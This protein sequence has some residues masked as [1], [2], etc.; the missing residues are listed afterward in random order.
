MIER[1]LSRKERWCFHERMVGRIGVLFEVSE[2]RL[3]GTATCEAILGM[4]HQ[5][6]RVKEPFQTIY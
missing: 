2:S 6:V 4:S 3:A 1:V 5:S